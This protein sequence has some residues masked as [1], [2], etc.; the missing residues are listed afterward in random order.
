M[1]ALAMLRPSAALLVSFAVVAAARC[2][3]VEPPPPWQRT[4][5]RAPC[6]SY[7]PLREPFV[8]E[9]HVHTGYSF[10]ALIGDTRTTP[11]DAYAFAKGAALGLAPYDAL[12]TPLRTAQ[13]RRPLDFTAVTD[14]AEQFG[15]VRICETAADPNYNQ[16]ECVQMRDGIGTAVPLPPPQQPPAVFT[17]AVPYTGQP[18]YH[19][20]TWC[21]ADGSACLPTTSLVWQ[22]EQDAAEAA[23]DRTSACTFTSFVAYEWTAT[24]LGVNMHRNVIFRNSLVP[25]LPITAIEQSTA[26]GLWGA[27]Q[28]QCQSGLPG[29]DV[30]AIPH[31]ANL[32]LGQMFMPESTAAD[33]ALRAAM[34]PLVEM[35][36]HKGDSEC[37]PGVLTTDEACGFEK[38]R[39]TTLADT[40]PHT[41]DP[42]AFVRNVLKDGL[43]QEETLGVNPF[44]LGFVGGTDSHNA[45]P[46]LVNE[47]DYVGAGHLGT[48]D[49]TP[50]FMVSPYPLGGMEANPGGLT[51]VWAEENSRDALFAALRRRETYA[52]SGTR[53]IVRLFGGNLSG[54]SCGAGDFVEQ[55]YRSGVPM[56]GELGAVR[57][58][59]SP[60]FA[61][62]AMKDPGGGGEPSQPLQRVEIIKG[63]VDASGQTQEKVFLV[64]GSNDNGSSVDLATCTPTGS[65]ADSLCTVWEDPEF[66]ASQRAFYYARVLEN[67]VCRW[68]TRLCNAQGIDCTNPAAVPP[69]F[70]LCCDPGFPQTIQER[71]WTSPIWYRP[72]G[73]R[74]VSG[75]VTYGNA[76][77]KDGL[78]LTIKIASLPPAFDVATNPLTVTVSDDDQIYAVAIPAG[79]LVATAPGRYVYA[80]D[81]VGGLRRATLSV[82]GSG[83]RL[84][85]RTMPLDLSAADRV[86]H[87]VDVALSIGT[88]TS[89]YTRQWV[90]EGRR[91]HPVR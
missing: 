74:R 38:M 83:A 59:K 61:V 21:G 42:R 33:A 88:Y 67:P 86:D 23:Y 75:A 82:G 50:A 39:R 28:T 55:G 91:L 70:A 6:A 43:A 41:Y 90:A 45:T 5:T 2:A 80:A 60:R 87:I 48:R 18:P 71:A 34:E 22:A 54:I 47:A 78:S 57:G 72:E 76:P 16:P 30:L 89:T 85:L 27:L 51:V 53:P 20:F 36:Q 14:H 81:G 11:A 32:S 10:D 13:L 62:L 77:G 66:D 84:R 79:A 26:A 31:N 44:R 56:G 4:E 37:H 9:L 29:C 24:P 7:D 68:S 52:T 64:A 3:A 15:E 8:G 1:S 73:I 58:G 69:D 65:G 46:G 25:P 63:W 49:A 17:W 35:T 12:G 19:R 40:A